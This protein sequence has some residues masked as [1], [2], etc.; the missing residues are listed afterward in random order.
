MKSRVFIYIVQSSLFSAYFIRKLHFRGRI[1]LY[2][3]LRIF[4]FAKMLLRI[5]EMRVSRVCKIFIRNKVSDENKRAAD[6]VRSP[7]IA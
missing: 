1:L 4:N 7:V 2:N 5:P 6:S 3:K